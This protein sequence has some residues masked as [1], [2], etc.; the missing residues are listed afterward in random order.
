MGLG[1]GWDQGKYIP[2]GEDVSLEVEKKMFPGEK[3]GPKKQ[4]G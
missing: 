1:R 3:V 2:H 4:W